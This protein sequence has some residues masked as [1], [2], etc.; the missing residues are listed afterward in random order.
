MVW[1]HLLMANLV[2]IFQVGQ[3]KL[4]GG[5]CVLTLSITSCGVLAFLEAENIT[6]M[7][8]RLKGAGLAYYKWYQST[9]GEILP[10]FYVKII[11]LAQKLTKLS[12][13]SSISLTQCE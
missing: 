6:L 11:V 7:R 8:D 5:H 3:N 10:H 13:T 4:G 2:F 9:S 12:I 1:R